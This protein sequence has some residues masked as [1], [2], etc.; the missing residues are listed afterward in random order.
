MDELSSITLMTEQD[1]HISKVVAEERSRLRNFIHKRVRNEADVEDLLQEV[2][3]E[4]VEANRLCRVPAPL[5]GEGV[6][7]YYS[8]QPT[9]SVPQAAAELRREGSKT[10]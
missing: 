5:P 1:R 8:L 7:Q 4:L 6:A 10:P 9:A 2:F 3:Y